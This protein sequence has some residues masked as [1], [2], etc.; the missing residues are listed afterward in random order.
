[1]FSNATKLRWNQDN[2]EYIVSVSEPLDY[3]GIQNVYV[4]KNPEEAA[5]SVKILNKMSTRIKKKSTNLHEFWKIST[6]IGRE[7]SQSV[8]RVDR[9]DQPSQFWERKKVINMSLFQVWP[10]NQA[11]EGGVRLCLC[12]MRIQRPA[13]P[14]APDQRPANEDQRTWETDQL[15]RLRS[16]TPC[17]RGRHRDWPTDGRSRTKRW[18]W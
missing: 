11:K 14:T 10:K 17:P 9:S 7:R 3:Q 13:S 5:D 15:K 16:Q 12:H 18:S 2:P 6:T 8:R 1:M 4:C